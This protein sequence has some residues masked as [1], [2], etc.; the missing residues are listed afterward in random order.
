[1]SLQ[2]EILDA[3]VIGGGF[4][5][6]KIAAYLAKSRGLKRVLLLE[7]ETSLFA[8]SSSNNQARVH[9]GYH[10]P[11]SLMTAARSHAN[12]SLFVNSY[13]EA[14]KR[15]F[16]SIYAIARNNSKVSAKQFGQFCRRVGIPI[17]VAPIEIVR[18]FQSSLIEEVFL[19]QEFVFDPQQLVIAVSD[20]LRDSAVPIRLATCV[21]RIDR[22]NNGRLAVTSVD[23]H[24]SET[25]DICRYVFNCT[26]S[27]LNQI[28]GDHPK[29]TSRLKHEITELA[30]VQVPDELRNLSVTV[31][32][33]PFFSVMPSPTSS[34]HTLSHVR[35]TPHMDWVD[36]PNRCPSH[37]LQQHHRESHYERMR[38][39]VA[40][41]IPCASMMKYLTS[42]YETKT[43]LTINEVDDGRPILLEKYSQFPGYYAILGGKIDNIFDILKA[44]ESETF[45]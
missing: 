17:E 6:A 10:Y 3:V 29:T 25:I 23:Q 5:G 43:I 2:S 13:P 9:N 31:M 8:R 16:T 28:G 11:R 15:D 1:M 36:D 22:S 24:G 33:G 38:R 14:I 41:Y 45:A 12:F 44:L 35:Y 40:R 37:L 7:R 20:E 34:Y 42:V 18:L 26:Y 39:D 27:G 30:V 4:Y 32:D 21:T 19:T